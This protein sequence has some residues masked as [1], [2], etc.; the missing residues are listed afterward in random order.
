M[1]SD[2]TRDKE[3]VLDNDSNTNDAKK[4]RFIVANDED[5][6]DTGLSA[7]AALGDNLVGDDDNVTYERV[8]EE[9]VSEHS[10]IDSNPDS[11]PDVYG[12][13]AI[14][15]NKFNSQILSSFKENNQFAKLHTTFPPHR[16][17]R[18]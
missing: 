12:K 7:A 3:N 10:D 8:N 11:N 1:S 2:A 15:S 6:F 9:I 4:R 13:K 16:N 17:Q 14:H 5:D 18:R